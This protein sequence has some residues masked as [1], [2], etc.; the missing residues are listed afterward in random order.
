VGFAPLAP[1]G[2]D[3]V[4][5][6]PPAPGFDA[7]A[8]DATGEPLVNELAVGVEVEVTGPAPGFTS[9]TFLGLSPEPLEVAA[10]DDEDDDGVRDIQPILSCR[11]WPRVW[12]RHSALCAA[13]RGPIRGWFV[14]W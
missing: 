1:A 3:G 2:V 6:D 9:T 11:R 12:R 14:P 5:G 4:D 7:D 10:A 13:M 8:L